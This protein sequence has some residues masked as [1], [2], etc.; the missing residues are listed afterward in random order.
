MDLSPAKLSKLV[1]TINAISCFSLLLLTKL[2]TYG[3]PDRY[4]ISEL[5]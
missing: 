2:S 5:A 4:Y 1:H 3:C